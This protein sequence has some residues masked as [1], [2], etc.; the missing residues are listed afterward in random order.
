MQTNLSFHKTIVGSLKSNINVDLWDKVQALYN[1]GEYANA[2]R[3][4]MNYIN[5]EIEKKYANGDKT[6]YKIPHGSVIVQIDI[7]D[8]FF[9]ATTPFLKIENAKRVP[10]LRQV[11][12]LNFTPLTTSQIVLENNHLY[13]KYSCPISDAEPY[14]VYDVLR[15]ICMN[16]DSY[17]DEF[18]TKFNAEHIQEP[19]IFPYS[20]EEKE[21]AWNTTQ[22]YIKEFFEA[23]EQ[24]EN[25]RMTNYL[26]DILV[27]TILK[28]DY[29]CAL[30]G[31]IRN[32]LEK[33]LSYLNSKE[34]YYQR[35]STGKEFLKR[36]QN[37]E[38]TKFDTNLYKVEVFV[39]YKSRTNLES[40]RSNL[41][42]AF[43]TSEKEINAKDFVGATCTLE[44]GI[45]N[46]FYYNNVEDDMAEVLTEAMI[47]ASERPL[48]ETA[49][50]LY[51]A[52]KIIMT[53]NN[54]S[55]PTI[56]TVLEISSVPKEKKGFL[57]KLFG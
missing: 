17:D 8:I 41:K 56:P 44:Y 4:C 32:D 50:A 12:Q 43:E 40:I 53:S 30:Q 48:P 47:A 37:M 14:K 21:L 10:V 13:F 42:Y 6:T 15:E 51:E 38:R 18:I 34:E 25:K 9:S 1:A 11:T 52:V 31:N 39:P 27:I 45:L 19:T 46:L 24:L 57:G 28:I 23:Y 35:L 49:K 36:I 29:F 3:E 54:F 55:N 20:P 2:I 22:A 26:W 33:T 16:A 7:D 5:P